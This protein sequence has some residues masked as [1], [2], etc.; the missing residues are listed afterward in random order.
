M[1]RLLFM[2][3]WTSDCYI[4]NSFYDHIYQLCQLK[5]SEVTS[6]CVYIYIWRNLCILIYVQVSIV[7]FSI[8]V[9][10]WSCYAFGH[11]IRSFPNDTWTSHSDW[12]KQSWRHKILPCV[13]AHF[14]CHVTKHHVHEVGV[15]KAISKWILHRN[16]LHLP[17]LMNTKW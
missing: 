17:A 10:I 13:A 7:Q 8:F 5:C 6:V 4:L 15:R 2:K 3:L 1:S 9:N 14:F 11:Y 16:V 12:F